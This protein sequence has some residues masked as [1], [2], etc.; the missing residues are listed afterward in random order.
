M[1]A[2]ATT[3]AILDVFLDMALVL[4][5]DLIVTSESEHEIWWAASWP[6]RHSTHHGSED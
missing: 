3:T 1:S 5:S 2:V 6:I 4:L